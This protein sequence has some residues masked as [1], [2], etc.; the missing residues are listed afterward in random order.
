M[1]LESPTFTTAPVSL[2]SFFKR[3][4]RAFL[5]NITAFFAALT[6]IYG[7]TFFYA[8]G[9]VMSD[10]IGASLV[11]IDKRSTPTRGDLAAFAYSGTP[12][13]MYRSGDLFV[14]YMA[15]LPGDTIIVSGREVFLNGAFVGYAKTHAKSGVP[16]SPVDSGVIP[17]GYFYA[18][19]THHDSL[20]S[21]YSVS[22]LVPV[23]AIVGRA[24]VIF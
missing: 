22:G 24:H 19:S 4:K 16:L 14:K 17:H 9:F 23:S 10:S 3:R 5:M 6:L 8:I 18:R 20:D 15:G 7:S 11:V 13:G 12:I 21:R 2:R 1:H